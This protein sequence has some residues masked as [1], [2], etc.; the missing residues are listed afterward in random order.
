MSEYLYVCHFSN[1][2]IKVG[3]SISPKARIAS[4]TDR[5]GCLGVNLVSHHIAKCVGP[6]TPAEAALIEKCTNLTSKRNK[7][8]WFEGLDY[9]TVCAHADRFAAYDFSA[10][11]EEKPQA[12]ELEDGEMLKT[13][14]VALLGGTAKSASIILG[15]TV[16]AIYMWGDV[17]PVSVADRIN[18]ALLRHQK[19]EFAAFQ[20]AR[21]QNHGATT[22]GAAA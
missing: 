3:R 10:P 9:E 15:C 17:I 7:N 20:L 11:A 14:A 22:T 21:S 1:G 12:I 2:H 4:H 19:K 6:S 13:D 8:E 18:G 16:H 5:V